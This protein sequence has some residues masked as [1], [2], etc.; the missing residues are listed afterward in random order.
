MILSAAILRQPD[1]RIF[2]YNLACYLCQLGDLDWAK[3]PLSR[4]FTLDSS[5]RVMAL[6]DEDLQ[7]LWAPL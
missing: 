7:P 6:D 5:M 4:A 2:H 1:V 3:E